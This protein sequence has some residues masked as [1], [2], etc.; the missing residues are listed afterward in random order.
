MRIR[1]LRDSP[2]RKI[3]PDAAFYEAKLREFILPYDAVAHR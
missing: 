2:R 3:E 1:N